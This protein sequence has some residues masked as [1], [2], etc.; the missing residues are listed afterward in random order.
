MVI[1]ANDNRIQSYLGASVEVA[2][3]C[4][5]C[6]GDWLDEGVDLSSLCPGVN[7]RCLPSALA[8]NLIDRMQM[9]SIRF[10]I[11]DGQCCRI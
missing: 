8:D 11:F 10:E 4:P 9:C 7:S 6:W 2:E 1:H 3:W 5:C